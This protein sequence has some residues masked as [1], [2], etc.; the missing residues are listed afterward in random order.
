[1]HKTWGVGQS[2]NFSAHIYSLFSGK[3]CHISRTR[4]NHGFTRHI[5]PL[6]GQH[7]FDKIDIPISSRL[8]SNKRPAITQP[9]AGE[10]ASKLVTKA[11][12]LSEQVTDFTTSYPNVTSR[13]IGISADMTRKLS[14]K[15]LA[16][17]HDFSIRLS[18]RVKI[19]SSLSAAQ[20]QGR[21]AVFK[22]LFKA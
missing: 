20:G 21:Q 1:M 10:D 13:D 8:R 18:F 7:I 22:H 11:L 12:V 16:K 19:T 14:H 4:D 2:H 15:A 6:C 17:P 9:F 5:L 3:L